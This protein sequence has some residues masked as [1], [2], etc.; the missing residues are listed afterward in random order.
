MLAKETVQ[1]IQVS[2]K[3]VSAP[4]L[5]ETKYLGATSYIP[6]ALTIAGSDSS[7]GAGI[8]ADLKTFSALGVYGTSAITAI[9]AQNTLKVDRVEA[10]PNGM[11]RQQILTVLQDLS[12]DA[13]KIGMVLSA[14]IVK[15]IADAISNYQGYVILDPVM[16]AKSG[17]ALLDQD[18]IDCM[19]T[20]LLPK[21]HLI[22]PN[23]PEVSVLSNEQQA[24]NADQALNQGHA[25]M[26]LG[27]KAVLVKGGHANDSTCTDWLIVNQQPPIKLTSPRVNTQN[28]HGTGCTYSAAIAAYLA[29]SESL[30]DAVTHAHEY[31]AQAIQSA[32]QLNIGSGHG[33]VH[34][35]HKIWQ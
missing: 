29:K 30:L 7:G 6:I 18:A 17:D 8:Q 1:L 23:L 16:I 34:H 13:I 12:V 9:T 3:S 4:C 2:A 19:C 31:L 14:N 33:P 32:D 27:A 24:S 11:V 35:F 20:L 22:T 25:L 21:A 26:D 10:L 28:T 5:S 15:E